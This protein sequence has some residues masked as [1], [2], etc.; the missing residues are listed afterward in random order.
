MAFMK[1][2]LASENRAGMVKLATVE[3]VLEGADTNKAVTP[4]GV[5]AV[6]EQAVSAPAAIT[7]RSCVR[8]GNSYALTWNDPANDI[9]R[10]ACVWAGTLIVRKEG[11][12]PTSPT[13][14]D[15]VVDST[16]RDAYASTALVDTP[17]EAGDYKYRAFPYSTGGAYSNSADNNFDRWVI[18]YRKTLTESAPDYRISYLGTIAAFTPGRMDF[19]EG[20]F[21]YGS[22][23]NT[24]I[25]SQEFIRPCMLYNSDAADGLNGTVA[26]YLDPDDHTKKFGSEDASDVSNTDFPGNA[27]VQVKTIYRKVVVGDGHVDKY[28]SNVKVDDDYECYNS[29][30]ADG[31]YAEYWYAPMFMASLIDGKFRSLAGQTL[32][33]SKTASQ[34]RTYAQANGDGW[35]METWADDQFFGEMTELLIGSTSAQ[36]KIGEGVTS[37][38]EASL[39]ATGTTL[40]KGMMYGSTSTTAAVKA[41][42]RE[43]PWGSQW[44]RMVG[45]LLVDGV[46]KVKMTKS[47]VDGS[48]ANDYNFTG[49]GY[50]TLDV[51][52][53]SGTSGAYI[54]DITQAGQYGSFPTVMTGGTESTYECDACWFSNSGTRVPLRGGS[55]VNGR[56]CGPAYLS[57]DNVATDAR[58]SFSA[59]LS[60]HP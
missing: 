12:F 4:A 26:Y 22:W 38:G 30:Q 24:E 33:K 55:A 53:P 54:K 29:K 5:K 43:N 17:A 40:D 46:W 11:S 6:I 51:P 20:A 16:T 19:A 2:P 39:L 9:S 47:T 34:E 31:T 59:A 3:E 41:F 8:T 50:I 15:I 42:Y 56:L 48:E 49:T 52:A 37:G 60:Y 58:W 35:D 14:G 21:N 27:M 1:G 18:G 57:A 13:D 36:S 45:V 7:N 44:R 23:V 10:P 32:N 28:Y 25:F